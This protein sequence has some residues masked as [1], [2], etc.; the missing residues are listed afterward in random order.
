MGHPKLMMELA[1]QVQEQL[2]L[3]PPPLPPPDDG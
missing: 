2:Q 1:W 3:P